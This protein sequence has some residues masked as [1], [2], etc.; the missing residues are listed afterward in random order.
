MAWLL[1]TPPHSQTPPLSITHNHHHMPRRPNKKALRYGGHEER[2]A[3][4]IKDLK[5]NP[6]SKMKHV[7]ARAHYGLNR[8]TL[9]NR[10]YGKTQ[11]ARAA[12]P[13]QRSLAEEQERSVE[14]WVEKRDA[15][16]YPLKHK[17]LRRVVVRIL[18]GPGGTR[19]DRVGDHYTSRFLKRHPSNATTVARAVDRLPAF[20]IYAGAAHYAGWHQ[21]R[22]IDPQTVFAYTDN[23]WTKD[24]V[25]L[26]WL[27]TNTGR[28]G[29]GAPCTGNST[30][31]LKEEKVQ[32]LNKGSAI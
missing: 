23:G 17:E 19:C 8:D 10:Y 25:G 9:H 32:K 24:Y 11:A 30:T 4:A 14:E 15:L 20:Y 12:H 16:G 2:V 18:D 31:Y 21:N 29:G 6:E 7:A 28:F 1:R 27:R 26:E 22:D 5:D 3:K 13:E